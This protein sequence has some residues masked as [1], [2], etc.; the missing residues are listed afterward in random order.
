MLKG[1]K[2]VFAVDKVFPSVI[3]P[4]Y[5]KSKPPTLFFV[6]INSNYFPC[7]SVFL[8]IE[9]TE[10]IISIKTCVVQKSLGNK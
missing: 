6:S 7:D 8:E 4:S 2:E 3:V 1:L 9:L 10:I 5:D